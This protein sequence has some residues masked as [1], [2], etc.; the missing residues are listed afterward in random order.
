M[1]LLAEVR[2]LSNID[3]IIFSA[4]KP[5]LVLYQK[6][7]FSLTMVQRILL[8]LSTIF[9]FTFLTFHS[10]Y[11]ESS[12]CS[13]RMNTLSIVGHSCLKSNLLSCCSTLSLNHLFMHYPSNLQQL[14]FVF[15][16]I[17]AQL[18][19]QPSVRNTSIYWKRH[20][21]G[22]EYPRVWS[23]SRLFLQ[24]LLDSV[25]WIQSTI[26]CSCGFR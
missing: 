14:K 26:L 5:L 18:P 3:F 10:V 25:K 17:L 11:F 9:S 7:V 15:C 12:K 6:I 21:T 22:W 4:V 20:P 23:S 1:P 16:P 2:L 24:W 19:R 13:L 8:F